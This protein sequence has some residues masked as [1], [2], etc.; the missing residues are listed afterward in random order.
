VPRPT[1]STV[2][3]AGSWVRKLSINREFRLE[4]ATGLALEIESFSRSSAEEGTGSWRRIVK[5]K[6]PH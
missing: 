6:L 2:G 1:L 5:R 3:V 4:L